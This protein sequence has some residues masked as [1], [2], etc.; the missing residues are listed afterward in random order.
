MTQTQTGIATTPI[1]AAINA[2]MMTEK[3]IVQLL[4]TLKGA[5]PITFKAITNPKA[6]KK[7]RETGEPNPYKV[8]EH[9]VKTNGM[10]N[11]HYDAGVIRRLEKE[12]K[13]EEDFQ[14]G[15]SFH[16][17]VLTDNGKLTPLSIHKEDAAEIVGW[18]FKG[19]KLADSITNPFTVSDLEKGNGLR[20]YLRYMKLS[21]ISSVYMADEVEMTWEGLKNYLPKPSTYDNQGLDEPLVFQVYSLGNITQ[22]TVNNAH[23]IITRQ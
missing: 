17:V 23:Y 11:F 21:S 2:A 14:K 15:G 12:G 22:M 19:E 13:T 7:N 16:T 1:T 6:L 4:L 10:V 9:H 8:I 20:L 5:T 3:E 18:K